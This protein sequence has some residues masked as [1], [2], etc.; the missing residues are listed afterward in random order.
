MNQEAAYISTRE[1][2]ELLGISLRTAQLWVENGALLAWKTSGGHRRILLHSVQKILDERERSAVDVVRAPDA[3]L[4]VAIVE[5]DPDVVTLLQMTLTGLDFPCDVQTR[6]DGFKGLILLGT[7]R[8]DVLIAD[9][10]MP[11]MDGFRMLRSIQGSEFA[12]R[13]II[14]TTALST[15]EITERGGVPAEALVL[16]KPYPLSLLENALRQTYTVSRGP[17]SSGLNKA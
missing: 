12:P 6:S 5:D 13:K 16:Q 15:S 2:A 7:F 17:S 3:R 14:V 10:N 4:K 8:P 11:D 9:L 1:A